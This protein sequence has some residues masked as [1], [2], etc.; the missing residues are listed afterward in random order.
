[1]CK[2]IPGYQCTAPDTECYYWMGT[3][4][5]LDQEDQDI[6]FE[7]LKNYLIKQVTLNN[8]YDANK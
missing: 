3:F 4:C 2:H 6:D 7:A 1:M 8:K 5:E